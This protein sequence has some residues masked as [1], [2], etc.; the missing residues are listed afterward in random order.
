[1]NVNQKLSKC[2]VCGR[3]FA[4]DRVDTHQ[5]ICS[6]T[7]KKT[8]KVFDPVKHRVRGTEAEAYLKKGRPKAAPVRYIFILLAQLLRV[9]VKSGL[10]SQLS[11]D[12]RSVIWGPVTNFSF[13]RNYLIMGR[14]IWREDSCCCSSPTQFFSGPISAGLVTNFIA[15]NLRLPQPGGPGSRIYLPQA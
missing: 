7:K 13:L 14:P 2:K 5:E 15:S 9:H 4:S 8:R 12:W 3:Q 6:R 1:M 11:Y 10:Q